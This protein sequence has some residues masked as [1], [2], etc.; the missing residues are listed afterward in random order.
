M[1]FQVQDG[2]ISPKQYDILILLSCLLSV[3]QESLVSL[4]YKSHEKHENK[5]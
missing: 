2:Q 3:K 1:T 5:N 4:V